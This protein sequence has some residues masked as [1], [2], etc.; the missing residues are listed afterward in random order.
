M[1]SDMDSEDV[2]D[3]M[4]SQLITGYD[5]D[6]DT[7][8]DI[9]RQFVD[10]L[11]ISTRAMEEQQGSEEAIPS[12]ENAVPG[13]ADRPGLME[14]PRSADQYRRLVLTGRMGVPLDEDVDEVLSAHER[15]DLEE[16]LRRSMDSVYDE[17]LRP[18]EN[19]S[20]AEQARVSKENKVFSS[21]RR[22]QK[23]CPVCLEKKMV[24]RLRCDHGV[25]DECI[26]QWYERSETCPICRKP[27][28]SND[29]NP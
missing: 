11:I 28:F 6:S 5:P 7:R 23:K 8:Q 29:I 9:M 12:M 26:Q 27:I 2:R 1:A 19:T 16:A 3:Y 14:G 10:N 15:R 13:A 24:I 4:L 20:T 25:C 21:Y 17:T 18:R 22:M